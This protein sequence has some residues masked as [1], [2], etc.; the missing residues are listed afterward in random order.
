MVLRLTLPNGTPSAIL[1][2][3]DEESCK[4]GGAGIVTLLQR[5]NRV[6]GQSF[7]GAGGMF[8][9]GAFGIGGHPGSLTLSRGQTA[10]EGYVKKL[11]RR[12]AD[13]IES[14][15]GSSRDRTL[16]LAARTAVSDLRDDSRTFMQATGLVYANHSTLQSHVDGVGEYL[17]LLS[18]GQTCLFDIDGQII[19]FK[20]GD[21][22][23]FNGGAT[24]G[25]MHGVKAVHGG[26]C[27]SHLPHEIAQLRV[28]IQMRQNSPSLWPNV[29]GGFGSAFSGNPF[30]D[31][32]DDC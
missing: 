20:S 6:S 18:I 21:A 9:L 25:V 14:A 8:G 26:T 28:S 32:F 16:K 11:M 17:V 23:V 22:L 12:A 24:H 5:I 10:L 1:H 29:G 4:D 19:P 15:Y 2:L 30:G 3:V 13:K 7:A 27:P 31:A